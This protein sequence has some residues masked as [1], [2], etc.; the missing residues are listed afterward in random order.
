M[1]EINRVS[2]EELTE[3][4]KEEQPNNGC[5]KEYAGYLKITHGGNVVAIYSDAMEPEDC[6]FHRDLR[7][8]SDAIESAYEA[9]KEDA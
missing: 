3:N 9:G 8:V 4:E 5:G 6:G 1:L 7:W 2:F